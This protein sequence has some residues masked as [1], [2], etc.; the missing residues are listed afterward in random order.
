MKRIKWY[1]KLYMT[2]RARKKRYKIVWR[3][4]H[5]AGLF[6]TYLIILPRYG[7]NQLEIINSSELLQSHY[8]YVTTFI[9]GIAI[10]REEAIGLV[11]Q[12]V[13]DVINC[14]GETGVRNFFEKVFAME[15]EK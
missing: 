4:N 15:E 11:E 9:V 14:K 13:N 3:V 5:K 8:D 7:N 12:I 1:R 10:G 2:E 6:N